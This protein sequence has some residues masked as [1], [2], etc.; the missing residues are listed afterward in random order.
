MSRWFCFIFL[1]KLPS[2]EETVLLIIQHTFFIH[3]LCT[4]II[5]DQ[6]LSIQLFE[7]FLLV[8][9][10]LR[11]KSEYNLRPGILNFKKPPAPLT[12]GIQ[13]RTWFLQQLT[14][15]WASTRGRNPLPCCWPTVTSRAECKQ[16][17]HVNLFY[18]V[19]SEQTSANAWEMARGCRL[20]FF[21]SS[22]I[23]RVNTD[24]IAPRRH[25]LLL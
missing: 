5:I 1:P 21:L 12:G 9:P 8:C 7:I 4:D 3:G 22:S 19:I 10:S 25:T 24:C 18:G 13:L 14:H 23:F 16:R 17:L 2:T 6:G 11:T 15:R 20:A